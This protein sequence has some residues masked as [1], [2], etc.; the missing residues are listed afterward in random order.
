MDE[1]T[2]NSWKGKSAEEVL[3]EVLHQLRAP[4]HTT[5]GC[6]NVL[7]SADEVPLSAEQTQQMI[8]LGLQSALRVKDVIDS[9]SLYMAE[10]QND[11]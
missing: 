10:K 9:I 5:V 1:P 7:K 8:D 11:R 6:L 4:V 3:A 2:I